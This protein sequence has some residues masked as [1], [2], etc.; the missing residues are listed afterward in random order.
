MEP[1]VIAAQIASALPVKAPNGTRL[2]GGAACADICVATVDGQGRVALRGPA[3]MMGW[4]PGQDV[5][6]TVRGGVV[7]LV[8]PL[9]PGSGGSGLAVVLDGR[10]RVLIPYG[11]RVASGWAPGIRLMV[12]AAPNEGVVAI[13][14]VSRVVSAL[15]SSP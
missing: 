4:K 14:A 5:A 10:W 8:P 15:V 2:R 3:S 11:I 12:V 13:L 1:P 6:L 7:H 9:H